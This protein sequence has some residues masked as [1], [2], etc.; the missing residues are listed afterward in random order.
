VEFGPLAEGMHGA[1][2]RVRLA[3]IAPLSS[4]YERTISALL[5]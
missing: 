3:D 5:S 2:E 4:I 1:N